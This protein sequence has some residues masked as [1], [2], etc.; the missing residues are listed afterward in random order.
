MVLGVV[1]T[2]MAMNFGSK[3]VEPRLRGG[4]PRTA[5]TLFLGLLKND[6]D[7]LGLTKNVHVLIA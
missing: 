6:P 7:L 1:G 4:C 3:E 5:H 2:E